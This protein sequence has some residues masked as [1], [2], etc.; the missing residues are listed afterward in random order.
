MFRWNVCKND[1]DKI[2]IDKI[3]HDK[4]G[5]HKHDHGNNG[6]GKTSIRLT[7]ILNYI[8][9]LQAD[10]LSIKYVI[11]KISIFGHFIILNLH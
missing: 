11:P 8:S 9:E 4:N 6:H 3:D 1:H 5:Q 7:L 2:V 10:Y